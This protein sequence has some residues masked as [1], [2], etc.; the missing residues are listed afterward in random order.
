MSKENENKPRL[1]LVYYSMLEGIANV[2]EFGIKKYGDREDWRNTEEMREK[3]YDAALRHLNKAKA[4]EMD[5]NGPSP[6]DEESGFHH[7][8]HA[9]C[10]LMFLYE[11]LTT[12]SNKMSEEEFAK[13][14]GVE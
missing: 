6:F 3:Y 4:A 5:D 10:C 12:D 8:C 1:G 9:A 14:L 7:L 11:D 13:L 2:R